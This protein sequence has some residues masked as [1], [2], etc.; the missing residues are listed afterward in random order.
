M[1]EICDCGMDVIK[2]HCRVMVLCGSARTHPAFYAK[3]SL[4]IAPRNRK[5]APS[6]K[7]VNFKK[8]FP[9]PL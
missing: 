5:F 4:P 2:D 6:T 1:D 9:S 8:M 3:T 7:R